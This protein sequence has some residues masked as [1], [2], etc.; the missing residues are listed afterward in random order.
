MSGFGNL[1][2][3]IPAADQDCSF[4]AT[5]PKNPHEAEIAREVAEGAL[6]S[7]ITFPVPEKA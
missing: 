4:K 5:R 3:L 2:P 1:L 6:P 7:T